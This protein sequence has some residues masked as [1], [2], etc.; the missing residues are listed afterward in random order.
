MAKQPVDE[1]R[2]RVRLAVGERLRFAREALG[3]TQRQVADALGLTSLSVI[4]YEAGRTPFP[5]DL[6]PA[7]NSQGF[8]GAWVATGIP[9]LEGNEARERFAAVLAWLRREAAIHDLSVTPVQEMDIAWYAFRRLVRT[10]P[11]SCAFKEQEILDAVRES[12]AKVA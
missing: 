9:S 12:L 2:Q 10:Q 7:L 5:T 8:D 6:L 11:P 1:E 3:R 4:H